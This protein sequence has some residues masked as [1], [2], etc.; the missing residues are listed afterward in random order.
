MI[1]RVPSYIFEETNSPPPSVAPSESSD[2]LVAGAAA[3]STTLSAKERDRNNILREMLETE[4]K[5][6][7]DLEVMQVSWVH[8][9]WYKV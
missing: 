5:Y 1:D 3:V 7:Q 9:A 8:S 6:V 4:R 2:S